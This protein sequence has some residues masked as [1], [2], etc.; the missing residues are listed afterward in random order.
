MGPAIDLI[1]DTCKVVIAT[2]HDDDRL[3]TREE[4]LTLGVDET[5]LDALG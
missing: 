5:E 2:L 3:Y 4:V 1:C